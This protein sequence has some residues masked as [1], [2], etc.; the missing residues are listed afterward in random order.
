MAAI[1]FEDVNKVYPD[2]TAAVAGLDLEIPDGEFAILVG[3]SG[4]G[5]STALRMVAGLEEVTAGTIRIGAR[6]VTDVAPK[7]RDIAMVFQ[8]YALYPHMSVAD[9]MGFALR[10]A[11]EG[12]ASIRPRV[13]GVA[14]RLGIG[15]LLHRRPRALSGGQRQRVALGRAIVREPA[16]FLMDEPLSNLD[17]KLRV[18]M[19]A[20]IARL[21]QELGTTVLYVTHDQVEAMTM[22]D[23]VAVMRDGRLEQVDTPQALYDRPANLFVAAFIGSPAMNLVRG[24]L[25]YGAEAVVLQLGGHALV[26]PPD[27]ALRAEGRDQVIVGIRPEALDHTRQNGADAQTLELPVVLAESLGSDTL[28]HLELDADGVVAPDVEIELAA[29]DGGVAIAERTATLLTARLPPHTRAVPGRVLPVR[30]DVRA[31]HFFDPETERAL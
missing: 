7:D 17:A 20:Y 30:V 26:V 23:R 31:L 13:G 18:E 10:M 15:E 16:A 12:K 9:N 8:S 11:G 6:D 22:G 29:D 24:R 5:K 1:A 3:P 27:V 14:D 21:H 28:V 2:G 19:R 25:D 4:S